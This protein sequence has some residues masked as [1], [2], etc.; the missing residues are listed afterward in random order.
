MLE[1]G[2]TH[3]DVLQDAID[4]VRSEFDQNKRILS[5]GEFIDVMMRHPTRHCRSS[6]QYIRD[7]F[8]HFGSSPRRRVWGMETHY[9]LF[10]ATFERGRERMVGQ[11]R[12]Q[13]RVFGLLDN[14]VKGGRVDKLI[15]LHGPNGSAKSTFI[16]AIARAMEHYSKSD[17][18][19]LYRFNW[20]FPTEKLE[21]T[22]SI[23]FNDRAVNKEKLATFA[24]LEEDLIDARMPGALGD[25]PLLLLPRVQRARVID[26]ALKRVEDDD[27]VPGDYLLRGELSHTNKMIFDALLT[28]YHGDL[29]A[30]LKHVQVER[31]FVSRRYRVGA[32]TVEPQMRVDAG[33][34]QLTV[35]RSLQSLPPVLQNLTLFRARGRSRRRQPRPDRVRRPVQ[36]PPRSQ[37]VLA[38]R[39]RARRRL[40]RP[41]HRPPRSRPDGH[42]QRDLPRRLQ[43]DARVRLV[44]GPHR[45]GA[46]A[47]S[48]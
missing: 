18:G 9:G 43:A 38:V 22:G 2:L 19:A 1:Q 24:H 37:Q 30:V 21:A 32:V 26:R 39:L 29:E 17:E 13:A 36:A 15:L 40:P 33:V 3:A 35:D 12:A 4:D 44:Q 41:A 11:E 34:R 14:F 20:V 28:A 25:H 47:V 42:R 8:A 5:F 23:G 48:A 7:C 27:F 6:V 10:D 16:R 46:P 45:A 31:F